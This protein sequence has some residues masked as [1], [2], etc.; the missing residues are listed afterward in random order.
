MGMGKL[1]AQLAV[2][3]GAGAVVLW[4]INQAAL[5]ETVAELEASGG[6]VHPYVVDVSSREAIE[7]AT[8]QVRADAGDVDVLINNAGIVRGK[9]FWEHDSEKDIWLTMAIN[10]LAP[11]YIT[12][13]FLPAMISSG[14]ES[15]V[16]NIASA[17]GLVSNPRMSVYCSSKWAAV[18]WS[19]SLRLELEQTG[20]DHVKVTT[21]CPSYI[22]TGMFEG[23][24]G[25]LMTPILTP[26]VVVAKVWKAM[27]T[28]EPMLTM[29]WS[30]RL[31]SFAKGVLPLRAWDQVA[32]KVFGV[33]KSMSE[34]KGRPTV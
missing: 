21:V 1:Y 18:G 27:K 26:E 28:G 11:M 15:R 10:S 34:F 19:D 4:D 32:G 20:N 31:S 30:V 17:A 2:K 6:K 8:A 33:Y 23:A 12:R 29:P 16:V 7:N 3:E 25:P 14:K 5:D 22:S 13:E 24:R 9:F